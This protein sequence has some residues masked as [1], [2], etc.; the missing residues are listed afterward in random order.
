MK[1]F[2][3]Y[4]CTIYAVVKSTDWLL[5]RT[6][7]FEF[8]NSKMKTIANAWFSVSK[9]RN[10][11]MRQVDQ[12]NGRLLFPTRA[13]TIDTTFHHFFRISWQKTRYYCLIVLPNEQRCIFRR[14]TKQT[15]QSCICSFIVQTGLNAIDRVGCPWAFLGK[16]LLKTGFDQSKPN[17]LMKHCPS[18]CAQ[19]SYYKITHSMKCCSAA[20]LLELSNDR[21]KPLIG[22]ANKLYGL[23]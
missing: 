21:L 5:S 15:K 7:L 11:C 12:L 20:K 4:I 16:F 1:I 6:H 8:P 19:K 9:S 3:Q 2:K 23:C 10:Q 13:F 22:R 18:Y 17:L 14:Q